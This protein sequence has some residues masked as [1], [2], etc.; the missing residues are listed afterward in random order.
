MIPP[1]I[2]TAVTN[3]A[4]SATAKD[5][6]VS[7]SSIVTVALFSFGVVPVLACVVTV[8]SGSGEVVEISGGHESAFSSR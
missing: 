6:G 4:L 1:I 7:I 8:G 5:S 3:S 2:L